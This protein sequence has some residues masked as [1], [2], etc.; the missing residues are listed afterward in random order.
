M[1]K[2]R[3]PAATRGGAARA[4][5]GGKKAAAGGK[6]TPT[7]PTGRSPPAGPSTA[8]PKVPGTST[9]ADGLEGITSGMKKI[10][11]NLIT[12][13]QKEEK[14]RAARSSTTSP[15][16]TENRVLSPVEFQAMMPPPP[17]PVVH[18]AS[19]EA[20][21]PATS[22]G[23]VI[24]SSPPAVSAQS[25]ISTPVIEYA[26]TAVPSSPSPG[27]VPLPASSPA[28]VA[29]PFAS[30]DVFVPYQP[31]GPSPVSVPQQES[32]KWLPPNTATPAAMRRNDLPVFT[33][34]SAIPFA[35]RGAE[36]R[37][38]SAAKK[39]EEPQQGGT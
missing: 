14:E 10:R 33:A 5:R 8:P 21:R 19:S 16:G 31:E 12:K 9:E 30:P 1:K 11:I 17:V 28:T 22:E 36:Q 34:T 18:P 27:Q 39:E 3:A 37:P 35:P 13:A 15:T 20:S 32:L 23:P 38:A 29:D 7:E 4:P 24:N 25:S 2:T 26:P 6:S